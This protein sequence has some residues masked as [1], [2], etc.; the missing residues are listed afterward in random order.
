MSTSAKTKSTT[1]SQKLVTHKNQASNN[2]EVHYLLRYRFGNQL[3]HCLSVFAISAISLAL[4]A[5]QSMPASPS[6]STPSMVSAQQAKSTLISAMQDKRRRS[7]VYDN[8]IILS[9]GGRQKDLANASHQQLSMADSDIEHCDHVHD[10]AYIDLMTQAEQQ[11]LEVGAEQFASQR[12]SLKLAYLDCQSA[13]EQWENSEE[14]DDTYWNED[15]DSG[16]AQDQDQQEPSDLDPLDSENDDILPDDSSANEDISDAKREVAE[17][18]A[19]LKGE[20][21]IEEDEGDEE[22]TSD[23]AFL[24]DYDSAHTRL[25]VKKAKLIEAYLLKP[26]TIHGQGSYQPSKGAMTFLPTLQYQTRNHVTAINQPMYF[27]AKE[28]AIYLWADNFVYPLSENLDETLG[29]SW[30]NKWLKISLNDGSLP[31][32]FGRELIASHFAAVDQA[33]TLSDIAEYQVLSKN[34]LKTDFEPP[35]AAQ[36]LTAMH[37][38][39]LLISYTPTQ[40]SSEAFL[41]HYLKELYGRIGSKYPELIKDS[42]ALNSE[43][44]IEK[45]SVEDGSANSEDTNITSKVIVTEILSVI[46]EML[47]ET[48]QNQQD[49]IKTAANPQTKPE[50][51]RNANQDKIDQIAKI[52]YAKL[53]PALNNDSAPVL[54]EIYGIDTRGRLAWVWHREDLDAQDSTAELGNTAEALKGLTLDMFIRY[55]DIPANYLP[56]PNLPNNVQVPNAQNSVDLKEYSQALKARYENGE[57]TELG[58]ILFNA[59][60]IYQAIYKERTKEAIADNE[61]N[62]DEESTVADAASEETIVEE[63]A[64]DIE[65]GE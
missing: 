33:Y 46:K 1:V 22:D 2:Y 60:D 30:Q 23:Q 34:K 62:S 20:L 44:D 26:L 42:Q 31:A 14:A 48:D 35:I 49:K 52:D 57:G 25:D 32:G 10:E 13:L 12:Q 43:K 18:E 11:G 36:H 15:N 47:D 7:Y 3:S 51:N 6:L 4:S 24:P 38:A 64:T 9:N 58:K 19:Y 45:E 40:Q 21:V 27:D 41:N 53:P 28:G 37:E 56:F 59:F 65:E 17:A 39:N 61:E 50:T 55:T 16:Y 29:A 8:S 54:Q 5:C 63:A